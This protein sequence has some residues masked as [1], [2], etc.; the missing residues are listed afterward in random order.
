MTSLAVCVASTQAGIVREPMLCSLT[1]HWPRP[2][3]IRN[4][5]MTPFGHFW[6]SQREPNVANVRDCNPDA[7]SPYPAVTVNLFAPA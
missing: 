6:R 7:D 5:S 1:R 3:Q 2:F 4:R